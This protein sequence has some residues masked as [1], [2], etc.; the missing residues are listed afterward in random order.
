MKKMIYALALCALVY[1][2]KKIQ[3]KSAVTKNS[4]NSISNSNRDLSVPKTLSYQGLLTKTDGRP[5]EDGTYSVIFRFFNSLDGDYLLWE[6]QQNILVKDGIISATL[7]LVDPI[8]NPL[9]FSSE[10]SYLEIVVENVPLS[11]RQALT[12]VL[13]SMKSDTAN[14]SQGGDYSDLDNLPD[15]SVYATKDTLSN[16]PLLN[17]L[18]SVAFTGD[19]NNLSNKPDLTGFTQSD[20]LSQYTLTSELSVVAFSN[21]YADL[22]NT[23]DLSI[24]AEKDTL[25]QYI[26]IDSVGTLASQNSDNV[27][28]TGG[29]VTGI[30]DLEVA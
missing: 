28:I 27:T 5:V 22:N 29:S 14:Y 19:Y 2:Q 25:S 23:P 16:F 7:G 4:H 11:P 6:E 8:D 26:L 21:E 30:T 10:E 13:Y 12:S 24:Y 17:S 15:L 3:S 1:G 9:D 18:D 20:T